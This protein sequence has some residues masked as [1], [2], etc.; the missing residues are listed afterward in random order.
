MRSNFSTRSLV[1]FFIS[2]LALWAGEPWNEKAWS[3]WTREDVDKIV[4]DSPWTKR[5]GTPAREF[6]S[7]ALPGGSGKIVHTVPT[8]AAGRV[9]L[10]R[11]FSA[12]TVR[13]AFVRGN[14]LIRTVPDEYAT[15]LLDWQ[16][17]YYVIQVDSI[18]PL[19]GDAFFLPVDAPLGEDGPRV[20][21]E[22]PRSKH[23]LAPVKRE[24]RGLT[25]LFYFA[26]QVDG[27][28]AIPAEETKVKFHFTVDQ[29]PRS[30]TFDLSK[31]S[32][33]GKPDL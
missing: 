5:G 3:E 8:R 6:G 2:G 14:Q 9:I 28:P 33:A 4:Q 25:D 11:W 29:V 19:D 18:N 13:Q 24:R 31:M 20:A 12:A 30:V 17:G 26:R 27:K 7:V 16:P 1:L 32:R 10:V 15:K 22:L 23:K 21:L